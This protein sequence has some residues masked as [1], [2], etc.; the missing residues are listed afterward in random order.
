MAENSGA[1]EVF[2]N[3]EL[4]EFDQASRFF[5]AAEVGLCSWSPSMHGFW[6]FVMRGRRFC[7]C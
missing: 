5:G 4:A 6:S 1:G 7:C 3:G 2:A